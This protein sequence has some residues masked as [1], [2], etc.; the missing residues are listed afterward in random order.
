MRSLVVAA[1]I[2][3]VSLAGCQNGESPINPPP[4]SGATAAPTAPVEPTAKPTSDP[5]PSG[6]LLAPGKAGPFTVGMTSEQALEDGLVREPGDSECGL[7]PVGSYRGF[8]VQFADS[9]TGDVLFGVLVKNADARTAEGI[10][11][12]D[13]IA[14]L[15]ETYGAKLKATT[16][17]YGE[18]SYVLTEG[19]NAI[20]FTAGDGDD[21]GKIFAIDVFQA[22]NPVIWDGC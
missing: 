21:S 16:G 7:T 22:D 6:L 1:C 2:G 5:T 13:S 8:S 11:V 14:Q 18:T 10:G 15:K 20:G 4:S 12:G 9:E 17:Q 3:L 19:N